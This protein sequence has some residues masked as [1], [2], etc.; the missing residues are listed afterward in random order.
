M[1]WGDTIAVV[2]LIGVPA[3]IGLGCLWYWNKV[4][5]ELA[6]MTAT[7]ASR[8]SDVAGIA[9]GTLVQ[10]RGPLRCDAPLS[11]EF[12][13]EACI[14]Y[15]AMIEREY[16]YYTKDSSGRRQRETRRET[17]QDNIKFA[18]CVF[19]DG[20]GRVAIRFAGAEVEGVE[21]VKRY[22]AKAGI[23]SIVGSLLEIGDTE[24]GHH[25]TETVIRAGVPVYILGTVLEDRS[26]GAAPSKKNPFIITHKSEEERE[27]SLHSTRLWVLVIAIVCFAIS[28]GLGFAVMKGIRAKAA[29]QKAA[30]VEMV[31]PPADRAFV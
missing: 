23:G 29:K 9:P 18:P 31:L 3:G 2:L 8:A 21:T 5:K 20:S 28:I 12:S 13:H 19:D 22:E 26:V 16:E 15:R 11:G 24:L 10:L 7:P 1:D 4:G 6:L 25:Y 14:Y 30:A 17:V 27:K